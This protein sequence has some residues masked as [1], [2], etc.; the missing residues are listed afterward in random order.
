MNGGA[1]EDQGI[2]RASLILR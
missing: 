2:Q 1:E